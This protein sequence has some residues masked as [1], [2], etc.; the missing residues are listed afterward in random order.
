[1]A[2]PS[3]DHDSL[4]CPRN[5]GQAIRYRIVHVDIDRLIESHDPQDDDV[6]EL[7]CRSGRAQMRPLAGLSASRAGLPQRV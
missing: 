1:M 3:D 5:G 2:R 7:Q 6:Q 4:R